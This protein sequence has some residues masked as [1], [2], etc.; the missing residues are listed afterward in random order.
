MIGLLIASGA[1]P[2]VAVEVSRPDPMHAWHWCRPSRCPC[3]SPEAPRSVDRRASQDL[4]AVG[5]AA[6]DHHRLAG[7]HPRSGARSATAESTVDHL[8]H[9]GS[10]PAMRTD[11][12]L[13]LHRA[14]P[15]RNARR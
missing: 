13:A 1:L 10:D 9:R 2:T 4:V 12:D 6:V 8:G 7:R 11:L 5:I 15:G 3:W 14:R